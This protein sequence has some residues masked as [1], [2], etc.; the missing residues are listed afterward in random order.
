MSTIAA[1]ELARKFGAR[2]IPVQHHVAHAH[3]VMGE[4]GLTRAVALICDGTGFGTDG[5]IWGGE[6]F[7]IDGPRWQRLGRLKPMRLPG[8]DAAAR[9]PRRSGMALLHAAYGAGLENLPQAAALFPKKADRQMLAHMITT[10]LSSPWTSSTGRLFD[11]V[12]ALLGI[13][14]TNEHEAQAAMALEAAAADAGKVVMPKGK[15][16]EVRHSDL[17]ELDLSPFIQ[18]MVKQGGKRR[19]TRGAHVA[20]RLFHRVLA[21]GFVALAIAATGGRGGLKMGGSGG[22]FCNRVL[23]GDVAECAKGNS[24]CTFFHKSYPP[25]DAGLAFG[26]AIY[27]RAVALTGGEEMDIKRE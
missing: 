19:D 16:F 27:A 5:S 13:C 1:Q 2:L 9:D 17:W 20:A 3:G 12:A 14:T 8:G 21:E 18:W 25:T 10:G 11:G 15:L 26:Q 6:L 4:H 24:I 23:E 22:R 7:K